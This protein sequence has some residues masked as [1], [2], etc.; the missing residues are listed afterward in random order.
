MQG[1]RGRIAVLIDQDVLE[2]F[3]E[4]TIHIGGSLITPCPSGE[5]EAQ[6]A[7][8]GSSDGRQLLIAIE[9]PVPAVGGRANLDGL[10]I[11][12]TISAIGIIVPTTHDIVRAAE[13]IALHQAAYHLI[14][15]GVDQV[16]EVIYPQR[17]VVR[18]GIQVDF[19]QADIIDPI[20]NAYGGDIDQ[21]GIDE[22]VPVGCHRVGE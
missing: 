13:H 3:G 20:A 4:I 21:V 1:G 22:I 12:W 11:T 16:T 7:T 15:Q 10:D 6:L 5:V 9:H 14:E 19:L 2:V 17:H 8:R 18:A